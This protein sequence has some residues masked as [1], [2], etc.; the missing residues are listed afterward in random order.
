M[1]VALATDWFLPRLG[2]IE[3]HLADLARALARQ[4]LEVGIVTTTP[5]PD[6]AGGLVVRRLHSPRLPVFDVAVSFRLVEMLKREFIAGRYDVIHAH[7]SVISPVG[8]GAVWAAHALKL[9]TVV[10]FAGVLL[11]SAQFLQVTDRIAGWSRWPIVVTAVSGLIANQL[12][13]ALPGLE[14]TLLPNGVDGAFWRRTAAALK[15]PPGGDIVIVSAMRLNRKKRPFALLEAFGKA[16]G[17][18][19]ARG[20][21]LMLR[22]AG[23]G[24]LRGRLEAHVSAHGLEGA[25]T[26]L[27][28]VS[29]QTLAENYR[30]AD[31]FALASIRESFGIAALEAR[32]AGLP[33][34]GMRRSGIVE[35]LRHDET[36]LLAEDDGEFA[37]FLAR[38][39][40]GDAAR[41]RLAET[42]PHLDRFEWPAVAAA[43]LAAYER[44]IAL[45]RR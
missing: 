26:F 19:A 24:P 7:I 28:A 39:A 10:T 17:A 12:R 37:Q 35:F 20:R 14:V 15:P 36:A 4:G 38:L 22:V 8:Y 34:V 3:L 43:H 6:V 27:G 2:G 33:V 44:A 9:P 42:D 18:G 16:Q 11:R 1:R 41:R 21:K 29:R 40:L 13:A 32:C 31:L 30:V 45:V 23:D 25:V 5:G